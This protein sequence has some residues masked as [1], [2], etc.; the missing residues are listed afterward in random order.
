MSGHAN[1]RLRQ[2]WGDAQAN[3]E[4]TPFTDFID[5]G[6]T[7]KLA[8]RY[9]QRIAGE[10]IPATYETVLR[11]RD[12]SRIY[13]EL[14]AGVITMQ[15]KPADL[16][17]IR[18]VTERRS[19]ALVLHESEENFRVLAERANDAILISDAQG[20]H[21][22]ANERAAALTGYP[23]SELLA[24]RFRDLVRPEDISWLEARAAARLR[25]EPQPSQYEI[26]VRRKD[27][28][29]IPLE[30]S[31]TRTYWRG[32]PATLVVA[33]DIT[34]RKRA[35]AALRESEERYRSLVEDSPE[36]IVVHQEGVVLFS[37]QAAAN[38]LGAQDPAELAGQPLWNFL[39]RTAQQL[40]RQRVRQMLDHG[41]SLPNVE[42]TFVRQDGTTR[43]AEVASTSTK[44][45]GAP[46]VQMM[47]RDIT[48]RKRADAEL[49]ALRDR[50][51]EQVRVRTADLTLVNR[52]L[53]GEVEEHRQVEEQLRESEVRFHGVFEK[54]TTGMCLTGADGRFLDVNQSLCQMLEYT[55]AELAATG[56][57]VVTHPDDL[58]ASRE[59]VR[60]LP[61]RGAGNLPLRKALSQEIRERS[62]D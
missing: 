6:E 46:A 55:H 10:A 11:R 14:N 24:N 39:D 20:R 15:G 19:A 62:L 43:I 12:G 56:F 60:S 18:D 35:E 25:G 50:L 47:V 1:T 9:Q 42:E 16:I 53:Q 48:D 59:C 2:M 38:F 49:L 8:R 51:E 57:A 27:G 4:G 52:Q 23:V 3:L 29:E 7:P 5:P 40:V 61:R 41:R 44:Y 31:V 22:F 30:L 58:P 32:A 17:I 21:V 34:E 37:N 26:T 28:Q 54:A 33:R 13:V 45:Q 36:P